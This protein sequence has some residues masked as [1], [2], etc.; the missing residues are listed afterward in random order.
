MM[1]LFAVFLDKT[2]SGGFRV[3]VNKNK[4]VTLFSNDPKLEKMEKGDI[5]F[6]ELDENNVVH[7]LYKVTMKKMENAQ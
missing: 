2:K 6:L 3:A 5:I 4:N 1:Y 7:R